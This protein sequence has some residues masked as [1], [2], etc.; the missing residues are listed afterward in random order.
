MAGD[1]AVIELVIKV[2]SRCDLACDYCYMYELGDNT[3][4]KQPR[5]ISQ[6][7]IDVAARKAGEHARKHGITHFRIIL[8]GGEPLLA[9]PEKISAAVEAFR[10]AMPAGVKFTAS[11]QTNGRLLTESMLARLPEDVHIGV[12]FDG[13]PE[14]TARHRLTPSGVSSYSDTIRALAV[15]RSHPKNYG[16]TLT[17]IDLLND[18]VATYH[19]VREQEPG[20]CDFLFP[21]T[22]RDQLQSDGAYGRWLA[23]VFDEWHLDPNSR[24]P[25]I[26]LFRVIIQRLMGVDIRCG[27]IGPPPRQRSVVLEPDGSAELLDALRVTGDGAAVT[28]LSILS[29][30]FDDIAAHPGYTQP[31]PCQTCQSCPVFSVCGGGYYPSRFTAADGYDNPSAYCEDLLYLIQHIQKRL[32]KLGVLQ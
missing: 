19:A 8:H 7:V 32:Q 5:F 21:L 17:V 13:G 23:E 27:F 25:V 9:G 26:R 3:W 22:T 11:M 30:S 24:A 29:S 12:S 20:A 1:S 2:A 16:G 31:E 28:G 15:L 14:A 4:K 6:D 10:E 18:P